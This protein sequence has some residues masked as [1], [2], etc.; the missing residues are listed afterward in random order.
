MFGC[1]SEAEYSAYLS[2]IQ[3]ADERTRT[4]FLLQLRVINQVLK[5]FAQGCKS[6]IFKRL[7]L[8]RVAECCTV[9]RSQWCQNDVR[10]SGVTRQPESEANI[11]IAPRKMATAPPISILR[12]ATA[13]IVRS[14]MGPRPPSWFRPPRTSA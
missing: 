12:P 7:S 4:A 3:R 14:G 13:W 5:G 6:R 2:R 8:L 9:L 1:F 11:A 10:S